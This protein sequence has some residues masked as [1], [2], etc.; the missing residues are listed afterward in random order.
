[1]LNK[2]LGNKSHKYLQTITSSS[3]QELESCLHFP[4]PL[5]DLY[6]KFISFGDMFLA[7]SIS[8]ESTCLTFD[9]RKLNQPA[10]PSSEYYLSM[11]NNLFCFSLRED[12]NAYLFDCVV[13]GDWDDPRLVLLI[14]YCICFHIYF[15]REEKLLSLTYQH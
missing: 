8:R 7:T 13:L 5:I 15:R 4:I 9:L 1:M 12:E 3:C 2:E 14:G 11:P 10:L 6:H